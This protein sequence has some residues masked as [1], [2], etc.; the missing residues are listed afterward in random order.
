MLARLSTGQKLVDLLVFVSKVLI[1][2]RTLVTLIELSDAEAKRAML[3]GT[4]GKRWNL[5]GIVF[6][7][8]ILTHYTQPSPAY[9]CTKNL[10]F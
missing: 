4:T 2:L 7:Y 3:S 5:L 9:E 10:S 8:C 6:P 1:E